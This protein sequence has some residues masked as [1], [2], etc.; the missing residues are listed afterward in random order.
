MVEDLESSL[1][2]K[3]IVLKN[4]KTKK[5]EGYLTLVLGFE[6]NIKKL[7]LVYEEKEIK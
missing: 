7:K 2:V 5:P 1:Y 6:G 3:K 4:Q